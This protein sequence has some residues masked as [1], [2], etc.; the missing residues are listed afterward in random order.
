MPTSEEASYS[1]PRLTDFWDGDLTH[2]DYENP[3]R[4]HGLA[5]FTNRHFFSQDTN[6]ADE[7]PYL[8]P[9]PWE[10][11]CSACT[12][13]EAPRGEPVSVDYYRCTFRDHADNRPFTIQHMTA[14]SIFDFELSRKTFFGQRVFTLNNRCFEDYGNV[15]IPKA[16]R[17]TA[18]LFDYFF[19]GSFE[20][21]ADQAL[22]EAI[23]PDVISLHVR[24][25]SGEAMTSGVLY[26]YQDDGD[27]DVPGAENRLLDDPIA[28]PISSWA[29]GQTF[30]GDEFQERWVWIPEGKR[31]EDIT[32]TLIF[33]GQLGNEQGAVVAR[34]FRVDAGLSIEQVG[35]TFGSQGEAASVTFKI[36]NLTGDVV[37]A[38]GTS[39]EF[40]SVAGGGTASLTANLRP[41]GEE[42]VTFSV[43]LPYGSAATGTVTVSTTFESGYSRTYSGEGTVGEGRM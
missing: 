35:Q 18:G 33:V 2:A 3:D 31:I 21:P 19:R 29:D 13:I 39:V 1:F 9:S 5:E 12:M 14:F 38:A 10:S 24:N 30:Q 15:L 43:Y 23:A 7:H 20:A 17:Y 42:F 37:L 8:F 4:G 6:F 40:S 27:E 22:V 36:V 34:R 25:A 16:V 11:G 28:V 41:G 26:L 32:F